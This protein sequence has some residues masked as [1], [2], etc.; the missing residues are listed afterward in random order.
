MVPSEPHLINPIQLAERREKLKGVMALSRLERARGISQDVTNQ[1]NFDLQFSRDDQGFNVIRGE[2]S[3]SLKV[4]CQRCMQLMELPLHG[5]ICLGI[6]QGETRHLPECYEPLVLCG[7]EISL[8]SLLD[9]EILLALPIAPVHAGS[10]CPGGN[11]AE[12]Y[13]DTRASPFAVLKNL[14]HDM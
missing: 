2:F 11:P 10:Q 14:K 8:E 13:R 12:T 6:V 9:E 5:K 7:N 3:V 1:V 4:L